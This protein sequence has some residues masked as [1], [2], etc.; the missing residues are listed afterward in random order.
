MVSYIKPRD[1]YI[2]EEIESYI[3]KIYFKNHLFP[4]L[5]N[6]FDPVNRIYTRDEFK[7]YF[8]DELTLDYVYKVY[9]AVHRLKLWNYIDN[10]GMLMKFKDRYDICGFIIHNDVDVENCGHSGSTMG[11]CYSHMK[12]IKK[13]RN[14]EYLY[15]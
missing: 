5:L 15:C 12:A 4:E 13:Y 6:K 2:P 11:F 9:I 10:Y 8:T 1:I 14:L 7:K 3:Y